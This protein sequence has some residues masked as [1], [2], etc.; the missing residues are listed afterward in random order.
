MALIDAVAYVIL[1]LCA[2]ILITWALV[3][4]FKKLKKASKK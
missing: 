3:A 1:G 4:A 2:I